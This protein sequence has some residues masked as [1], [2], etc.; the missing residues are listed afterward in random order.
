MAAPSAHRIERLWIRREAGGAVEPCE[1]L[2]LV[3]G[4][5][6]EGDHTFG[7]MRHVTLIF[8][9]DW[10]AATAEL[11][12][13]V[14]PAERRA[15]VLLSG[16]AGLDLVGQT[17]RLG[18]VR[19]E[20]KGETRPCPVMEKAAAGLQAALGPDGRGGVWGRVLEGGTLQPDDALVVEA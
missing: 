19:L 13:E 20:I 7:R 5:G 15:N 1:Q 8:A 12:E 3:A 11:G 14:D 9:Q 17:V 2:V 18:A 6:I 16:G 4:E 10:R